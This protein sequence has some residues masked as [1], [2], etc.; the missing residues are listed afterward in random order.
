MAG[1]L[2]L[3]DLLSLVIAVV[4][5][6]VSVGLAKQQAQAS[7]MAAKL[8][9]VSSS[10]LRQAFENLYAAEA[11]LKFLASNKADISHEKLAEDRLAVLDHSLLSL[12]LGSNQF[13][14]PHRIRETQRNRGGDDNY[15]PGFDER[16]EQKPYDND[17]EKR[18]HENSIR[19]ACE[20][21]EWCDEKIATEVAAL[22]RRITELGRR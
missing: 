6:V 8:V 2:E 20:A 7:I 1:Y 3:N 18:K 11:S 19:N 17:D 14:P 13:P 12:G 9:A 15:H 10:D 22:R 4:G 16:G 5:V 21:K